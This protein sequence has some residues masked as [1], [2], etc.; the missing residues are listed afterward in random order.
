[1]ATTLPPIVAR[2]FRA[3]AACD[4]EA[5]AA[6]FTPEGRLV[7]EARTIEGPEAIA[8]WMRTVMS[9]HHPYQVELLESSEKDGGVVIVRGRVSR[10]APNS[11]VEMNHKFQVVHGKIARLEIR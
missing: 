5:L 9:K 11:P 7:D 2:Y 1:M 3:E 4:V 8:S 10:H 6:C